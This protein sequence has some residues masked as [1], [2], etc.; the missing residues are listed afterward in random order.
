MLR[1]NVWMLLVLVSVFL[2]SSLLAQGMMHGKW[3]Q[4]KTMAAQLELSDSE[5]SLL[6]EKYA[7]SRRR[8]IDLKSAVER[9]RFEL[10]VLL[11]SKEANK[12]Q[13]SERY[14]SLEKARTKLSR[15]RFALLIEI[16]DI[17]G[18]ERFREL[19]SMHRERYG[20]R[21]RSKRHFRD[22]D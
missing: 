8:F 13:I 20:D 5:R 17:I 1:K 2:P 22:R 15:E 3:W 14:N 18:V 10:D 21:D 12:E 11:E 6:D 4:N 16:R 7:E 19:K 9:E